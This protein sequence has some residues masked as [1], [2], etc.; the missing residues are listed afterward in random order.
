[1]GESSS[2]ERWLLLIHQIPP[3]PS[4]FRAKIGR[5]LQR[6]GAVALKNSVYV[7]P[8][9]EQAL[10]DLQW[11]AREIANQGGEASVCDACF[12]AGPSDT[13]IEALFHA[14]RDADYGQVASEAR[15]LLSVISASGSIA[16]E[17]R[18]EAEARVERLRRRLTDVIGIDFLG[19]AGREAAEGLMAALDARMAQAP[20]SATPLANPKDYRGRTWVTRAG[21]H[22]DRIASAWLIREWID[23]E[24]T[25]KFVPARG[26]RPE[27]GELRFDMF[28]AEFT[29]DGE[30]CTFEVLLR[31][32]AITDPAL[33][34]IAEI[35]HAIDLK[36]E[37]PGRPET[38]GIAHAL[39]GLARRYRDDEARLRDGAALFGALHA[40]FAAR[41]RG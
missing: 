3:N 33:R 2:G 32:F 24:A 35:V 14:A 7:L 17:E 5:R 37:E 11:V 25:F 39:E 12:V 9:S 27:A 29:H 13:D 23:P 26:Y 4:Y 18:A 41:E 34:A 8:R 21:V 16:D 20:A 30:R 28:H 10:E 1:M 31:D 38:A 19:A 15:E 36:V 40:Y 22:V 6:L